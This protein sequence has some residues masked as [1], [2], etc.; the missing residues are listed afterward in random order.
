MNNT[1]LLQLDRNL[2]NDI[3]SA[4]FNIKDYV[5]EPV[6][7]IKKKKKMTETEYI[8]STKANKEA[9]DQSLDDI[10]NGRLTEFKIVNGVL[11]EVW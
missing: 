3:L 11:Q 7:N 10:K 8:T 1:V 4:G 5:L 6:K 9:L 2:F